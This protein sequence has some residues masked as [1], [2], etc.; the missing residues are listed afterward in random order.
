M[1]YEVLSVSYPKEVEI[2]TKDKSKHNEVKTTAYTGYTVQS[3]KLKYSKETDEL[4]SRD[5]E[6][7][8]VYS[9]RDKVVYKYVS[10][11]K[12]QETTKATES[13]TTA[14]KPTDSTT[15][16]A[17]PT[18]TPPATEPPTTTPPATGPSVG[19]AGSDTSLPDE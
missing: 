16:T 19:E 2:E 12:T 5:K 14:T 10:D 17:P 8:S 4:I 15:E 7:Y 9:K 1:E 3:Y 13:A 6:A 18:T 11:E